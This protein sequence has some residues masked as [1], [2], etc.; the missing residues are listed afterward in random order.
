MTSTIKEDIMHVAKK[1]DLKEG[2]WIFYNGQ[3]ICL[4]SGPQPGPNSEVRVAYC[5]RQEGIPWVS[6]G[7][8]DDD[9]EVYTKAEVKAITGEKATK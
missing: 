1:E 6:I 8:W 5:T 9:I 4:F 7:D 3:Y 2:D